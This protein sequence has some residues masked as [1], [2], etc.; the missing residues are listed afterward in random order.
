MAILS[1]LEMPALKTLT[2]QYGYTVHLHDAC[3]GQA[4]T[5]EP[6]GAQTSAQVYPALEEFFAAHRMT[7]KFY[8]AQ[9][10]NFVAR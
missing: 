4:F 2:E 9:K 1:L 10:L 6:L 3:G 5:L 7:V 8:D